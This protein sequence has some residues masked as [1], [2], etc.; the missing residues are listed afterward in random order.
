MN[1][2]TGEII[3]LGKLEALRET[4][5][6]EAAKFSVE[7]SGPA[8]DVEKIGHAVRAAYDAEKRR[9][10]RAKNKAARKARRATR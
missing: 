2:N 10:N 5:P 1:P 3:S 7:L 6:D 9:A 8:E 4:D